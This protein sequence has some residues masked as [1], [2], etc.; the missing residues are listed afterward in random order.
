MRQFEYL[1][2]ILIH[3]LVSTPPTL[4]HKDHHAIFKDLDSHLILGD[5]R[6]MQAHVQ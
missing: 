4:R 6:R 3:P 1:Q 5:Y 2:I